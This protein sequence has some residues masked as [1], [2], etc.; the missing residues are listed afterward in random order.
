MN[1]Y[2]EKSS[3]WPM[4]HTALIHALWATLNASLPS[5]Y[6]ASIEERIIIEEPRRDWKTDVAVFEPS[7]SWQSSFS[8]GSATAVADAPLLIAAPETRQRF[9]EIEAGD[10]QKQLVATIE[11]LSPSNKE[12]GRGREEY[13]A[14][15]SAFL[16]GAAHLLEIDVLRRGQYSL[17]APETQVRA[18]RRY[19][20]AACLH[21]AEAGG[22]FEVWTATL[23]DRLPRVALPLLEG[24]ADLVIDLN[25]ILADCYQ[26]GAFD[27]RIDYTQQPIPPLSP[28][29]AAWA[30]ELLKAANLRRE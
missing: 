9:V 14:K 15:Q 6:L 22:H 10:A 16:G 17:A 2:L 23:R 4:V 3:D 25:E 28:E 29:D 5:G 27:R 8:N 26:A 13:L 11:I 1:P 12:N 24:D 7:D 20:Y 21:R 30:D 18:V 19:D